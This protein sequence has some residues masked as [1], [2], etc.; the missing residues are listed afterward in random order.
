MVIAPRLW[1]GQFSQQIV[2]LIITVCLNLC[3][4]TRFLHLFPSHA[5]AP[6]V[7]GCTCFVHNLTPGQ[8]KLTA[9]SLKC[10]F[11][12]YSRL[13]KGYRCFS[14]DLHRYITSA[15]V[16]LRDHHPPLFSCFTF[17]GG[18]SPSSSYNCSSCF[19]SFSSSLTDLSTSA[20]SYH[21]WY[22]SCG[23]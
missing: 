5:N 12:G 7:F 8:D 22:C 9:K 6:R 18:W 15:D 17:F 1:L 13:Q 23:L 3:S 4:N 10:V 16:T 21:F 11:L 19:S 20:T 14:P 2:Q